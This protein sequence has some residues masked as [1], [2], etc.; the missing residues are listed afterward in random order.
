MG[1]HR[2]SGAR[3]F[4]S[5]GALAALALAV[6]PAHAVTVI[7]ASP[8]G[9]PNQQISIQ[10][11]S[12]GGAIDVVGF[13]LP[14]NQV[15]DGTEI[16]GTPSVEIEVSARRA[17]PNTATYTLTVDSS[18]PLVNGAHA[19]PFTLFRWTTSDADIPAGT[20]DGTANQLLLQFQNSRRISNTH[21]FIYA[22]TVVPEPGTYLGQV[23]YTLSAP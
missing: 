14:A 22:N 2:P 4:C 5:R 9:G 16:T 12:G 20:F 15:A 7:L 10:V 21:T 19:I 23:T 13:T 17:N 1:A 18:Q 3:F 11:G 6:A 8:G